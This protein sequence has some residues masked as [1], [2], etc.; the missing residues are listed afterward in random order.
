MSIETLL[1]DPVSDITLAA[2]RDE[3]NA[4]AKLRH[5]ARVAFC[6]RLA[7][8]YA[9]I[10]GT[11]Y[12]NGKRNPV[13]TKKFCAWCD[14]NIKSA[15]GKA[16][17]HATLYQYLLVGEAGNPDKYLRSRHQQSH[18]SI[19]A[20]RRLGASLMAASKMPPQKVVSITALKKAHSLPSNVATEVNQLMRAWEGASE[21]AR[22]QFLH[23]VSGRRSA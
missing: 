2:L 14:S 16:Y 7:A 11:G 22:R 5:N 19:S 4:L 21:E 13:G 23:M 8:A 15:T 17:S 6:A 1:A 20:N 9:L 10:A 3:L 18:D 12:G